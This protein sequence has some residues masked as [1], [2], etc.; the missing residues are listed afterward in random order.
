MNN[1]GGDNGAILPTSPP[2][3]DFPDLQNGL[4]FHPH[5]FCN[6]HFCGWTC[7]ACN[8]E[9][10]GLLTAWS[11]TSRSFLFEDML[12]CLLQKDGKWVVETMR[13]RKREPIVVKPHVPRLW[14][15]DPHWYELANNPR[16]HCRPQVNNQYWKLSGKNMKIKKNVLL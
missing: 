3:F 7:L 11:S 2:L 6:L 12:K 10:C 15:T 5:S 4:T 14:R 8:K 16:F 1:N 13:T 9:M